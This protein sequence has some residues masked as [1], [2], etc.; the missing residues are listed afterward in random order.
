LLSSLVGSL[1]V[2]LLIVLLQ[3]SVV[4]QSIG[5]LTVLAFLVY[6][7]FAALP[8]LEVLEETVRWQ[9][10]RWQADV[11]LL[12]LNEYWMLLVMH[13]SPNATLW[14]RLVIYCV[15]YQVVYRDQFVESEY[16]ELRS[17]LCVQKLL[18]LPAQKSES[19]ASK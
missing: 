13:A 2:G 19:E 9:S 7:R 5:F 16:R 10:P 18:G 8:T 11:T 3:W 6:T 17:R 12:Y 4:W 15:K 14:Q 1:A